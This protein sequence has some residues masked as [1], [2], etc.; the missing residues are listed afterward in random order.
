MVT[1]T[2]Q[3]KLIDQINDEIDT[4]DALEP[5]CHWDVDGPGFRDVREKY[6]AALKKLGTLEKKLGL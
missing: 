1:T 2:E 4:L 3:Q 5:F 6:K